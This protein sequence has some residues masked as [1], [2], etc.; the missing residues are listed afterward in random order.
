MSN[1]Y[2]FNDKI[3]V[4]LKIQN[5]IKQH[6]SHNSWNITDIRESKNCNLH[7]IVTNEQAG[8]NIYITIGHY[9]YISKMCDYDIFCFL[10]LQIDRQL[11][12]KIRA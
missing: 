6:L 5:I 2:N 7:I 1:F 9:M 4:I 11:K 3:K 10:G 12:H 8:D